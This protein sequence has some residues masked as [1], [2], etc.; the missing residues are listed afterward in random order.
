MSIW[1][2]DL[3]KYSETPVFT[4]ETVPTKLTSEHNTKAGVWGRLIL[5]EGLLDYVV[6]ANPEDSLSLS[7]GD[8]AIIEPQVV[9][10]VSPHKGA[11][12]RVEFYKQIVDGSG[13]DFS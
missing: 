1:P 10:F 9:H 7:K 3:V 8:V 4:D 13:K 2:D 12:F 11:A 5:L 6:P